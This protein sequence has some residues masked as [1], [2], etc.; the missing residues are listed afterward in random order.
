V[1]AALV[2]IL[3]VREE[4]DMPHEHYFPQSRQTG[5]PL[6]CVRCGADPDAVFEAEREAEEFLADLLSRDPGTV[7]KHREGPDCE[8]CLH[9]YAS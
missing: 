7:C 2:G 4:A 5:E 3:R 8:V 1:V 9:G 6:P